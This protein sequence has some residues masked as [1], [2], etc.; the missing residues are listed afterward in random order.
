MHEDDIPSEPPKGWPH[1][2]TIKEVVDWLDRRIPK[3][4]RVLDVGPGNVP[5]QRATDEVDWQQIEGR[6]ILR[7]NFLEDKLPFEDKSIDFVYCRHVLEDLFNPFPLM[8]EMSRVGKIGYIETPSPTAEVCRK[9][10]AWDRPRYRGYHHHKW[11]IWPDHG[12]LQFMQ[13][14]VVLEYMNFEEHLLEQLLGQGPYLWNTYYLWQDEIR[15]KCKESPMDYIL[16]KDYPR[17]VSEAI[18]QSQIETQ[19]FWK[20]LMEHPHSL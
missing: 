9:T 5:F 3:G 6:K 13:K 7:C 19:S 20:Y 16:H 18:Y 17:L 15:Y 11:L 1:W 12:V 10:E 2:Y 8:Q 14:S 4:S